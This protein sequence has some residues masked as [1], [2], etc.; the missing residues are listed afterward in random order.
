MSFLDELKYDAN[1]LVGAVIQDAASGE[2]LM[3]AFTSRAA[4]EK[5]LAT[6]KMHF[7]SRSRKQLWLKGE[8]SGHVQTVRELRV[9]CD[10]DCV[11]V[12]V[13]QAGGACHAGYRSCFFR[14]ATPD[15]ER[16]ELAAER[17]FDPDQV[18]R[19]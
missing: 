2:V 13:E 12:K 14:K 6:G 4:L 18:Y 3:F 9:D 7:W 15:G 8:S 10:G 19:A 5:T 16:L 1:G 11:L 17:L